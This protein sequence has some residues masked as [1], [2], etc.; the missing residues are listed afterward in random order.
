MNSGIGRSGKVLRRCLKLPAN[1]SAVTDQ[2]IAAARA[3]DGKALIVA[4][5]NERLRFLRSLRTWSVFGRGWGRRVAEVKAFALRLADG[6]VEQPPTPQGVAH[7]KGH[8]PH[9]SAAQQGSAAAIAVAGA[10]AAQQAHQAGASVAAVAIIGI[11]A[12]AAAFGVWRFW[13]WRQRRLQDRRA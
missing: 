8:V 2:V 3:A 6:A 13:H 5:C 4:I 7:G 10:A 11:V 12:V 9:A 1:S